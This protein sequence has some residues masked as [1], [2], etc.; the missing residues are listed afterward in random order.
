MAVM[1]VV[2]NIHDHEAQ[3]TAAE[4]AR[5]ERVEAMLAAA[6]G[7]ERDGP[8]ITSS[9]DASRESQTPSTERLAEIRPSNAT[10]CSHDRPGR[11]T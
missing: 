11:H 3:R 7:Y 1:R 6:M 5:Q 4:Q 10:K 8:G 9:V 2:I